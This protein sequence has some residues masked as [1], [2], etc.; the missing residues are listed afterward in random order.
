MLVSFE[1]AKLAKSKGCKCEL[2]LTPLASDFT[3][4]KMQKWLREKHKL[5]ALCVPDTL[6]YSLRLYG[7]S[8]LY[9]IKTEGNNIFQTYEECLEEGLKQLLN[10]LENE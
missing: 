7:L 6:G 3:Q 2:G 5:E 9:Y 1:T 8:P 4:S 10:K